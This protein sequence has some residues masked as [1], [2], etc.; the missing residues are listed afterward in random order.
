MKFN[1]TNKTKFY[2][3]LLF[4]FGT[5]ALTDLA[6]CAGSLK[7]ADKPG[8]MLWGENCGRCHNV[9]SPASF[10]DSEWDV[11]VMHMRTRANLT[12]TEAEKIAEFLK[13]SN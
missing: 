4:T 6:G 12:A 7:N 11:A 1:K 8:A 10:S 3:V 13:A 5:I 2:L 9:R